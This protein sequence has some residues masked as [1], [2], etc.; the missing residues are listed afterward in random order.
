[1]GKA[2]SPLQPDAL[3]NTP[4]ALVVMTRV[5]QPGFT[6]TRMMPNLSATRC[7]E[8]HAAMLADLASLCR[9]L[10]GRVDVLVS[11]A[12]PGNESAMRAAFDAPACFFEQS[13]GDLGDRMQKAALEAFRRG[14]QRCIL[15]GADVP[16]LAPADI[17]EALV[18]LDRADVVLGPTHDGGFYLI[19]VKEALRS[20]FSLPAYGHEQVLRQTIEALERDGRSYEL[21]RSISDLDCWDDVLMLLARAEAAPELE[22]LETVRY[23]RKVM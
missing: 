3:A 20:A 22:R 6:K 5:P 18:L 1:M 12:P 7:A 9:E 17:D 16:E 14:Y 10:A 4:A 23:L 19:G 15:V 2:G 21:L 13:D 11:Y 8:L